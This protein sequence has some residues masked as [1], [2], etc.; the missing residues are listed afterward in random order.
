STDTGYFI[1]NALFVG[2][3]IY[4]FMGT[5]IFISDMKNRSKDSDLLVLLTQVC[6]VGL[7]AYIV[8]LMEVEKSSLQVTA[9]VAAEQFSYIFRY[10]S[11][12][13]I[14]MWWSYFLRSKE[15]E[16]VLNNNPSRYAFGFALL[17]MLL[18]NSSM[19]NTTGGMEAVG[20]EI[21]DEVEDGDNIL[22]VSEPYHAMHRLYT[23]QITVDPEHDRGV[24][25]YWADYQYNW[26]HILND[27][28]IDWVIFTD[29]WQSYLDE[30]WV[31]FDTDTDY[32][33]YHRISA[34]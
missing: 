1:F 27:S 6:F 32:L 33:I 2:G 17:I 16:L 19:L 26:S 11:V 18:L 4:L 30:N 3:F 8:M 15:Q 28:D 25:G 29:D 31:K 13:I 10:L 9:V 24:I 12:L 20:Q 21:A 22:Y 14:P 7:I 5:L 34:L 23:L